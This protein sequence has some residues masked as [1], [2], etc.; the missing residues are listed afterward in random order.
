MWAA[1]GGNKETDRY[2]VG[3]EGEN[4][5]TNNN[6]DITHFRGKVMYASNASDET[7]E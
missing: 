5:T 6:N 4:A 2:K 1:E 3:E 7:F